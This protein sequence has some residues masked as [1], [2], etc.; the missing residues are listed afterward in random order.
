MAATKVVKS[1]VKVLATGGY[2]GEKTRERR[3]VRLTAEMIGR[4]CFF[5]NFGPNSLHP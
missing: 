1:L 4:G 5:V 2:S 3:K